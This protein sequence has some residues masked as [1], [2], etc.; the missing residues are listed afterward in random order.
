[1]KKLDNKGLTLVELILAAV[2]LAISGLM[3]ATT[4]TSAMRIMSRAILYKNV[5]A[6]AAETVELAEEQE[7]VENFVYDVDSS[8]KNGTLT[9]TYKKD[10]VDSTTTMSGQYYFAE[11]SKDDERVGLTYKE[12]LPSNFSYDIPAAPVGD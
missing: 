9:I 6:T 4:F 11:V 2:I 10:N 1:M 7:P 8:E 5:S 3:L 12:F